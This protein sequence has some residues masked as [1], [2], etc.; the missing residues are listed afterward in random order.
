VKLE[1]HASSSRSTEPEPISV[2]PVSDLA[3]VG[4]NRSNVAHRFV[5]D[6]VHTGVPSIVAAF[7][8]LFSGESLGVVVDVVS[9]VVVLN[10][11]GQVASHRIRLFG[12]PVRPVWDNICRQS[13]V[14]FVPVQLAV[15]P[16]NVSFEQSSTHSLIVNRLNKL[17]VVQLKNEV[18]VKGRHS[19]VLDSV[20]GFSVKRK[21]SLVRV[22]NYVMKSVFSIV[23][24]ILV[25]R[26]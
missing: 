23:P 16:W 25:N 8:D 15:R 19:V 20:D 26:R 17:V 6:S 13:W 21:E 1:E 18:L 4:D 12:I 5:P 3:E 9:W 22:G 14:Q 11:G 2:A 10:E 24:P 7:V